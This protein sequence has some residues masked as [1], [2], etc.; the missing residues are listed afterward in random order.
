[1]LIKD[2]ATI[3]SV[4]DFLSKKLEKFQDKQ[5]KDDFEKTKELLRIEKI[6]GEKKMF[7]LKNSNEFDGKSL[8]EYIESENVRLVR[9]REEL[10]DL[11]VKIANL[12]NRDDTEKAMDEVINHYKSGLNS[13]VALRD[14]LTMIKER[15]PWGSN[16]KKIM[17]FVSFVAC[18]LGIGLFVL[19]LTTDLDFGIKMLNKENKSANET[20]NFHSYLSKKENDFNFSSPDS[21]RSACDAYI[22]FY[23]NHTKDSTILDD[24]DY[25]LTGWIAIWH[26][27]QPFVAIMIVFFSINY[28]RGWE[29]V[30]RSFRDIPDLPDFLDHVLCPTPYD[31]LNY[32]LCGVPA[33][34]IL[35]LWYLVL[36][37]GKFVPLPA[38]TNIYR[39]YLDVRCHDA[40]SK[41]DFRTMIVS[42]EG[43][44]RDH[45]ALGQLLKS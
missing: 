44:I 24:E 39:F 1:M 31:K 17:I 12:N 8:L 30:K 36:V 15:Y 2:P 34:L 22:N 14:M 23:D 9:Q 33:L 11:S 21:L 10:I 25:E 41:P 28:S 16:K 43:K 5:N 29:E 27:I 3:S 6:E 7:Y 19:D 32:L 4:L 20:E 35:L 40:R 42:I 18:V 45:E 13:G 38:F 37:L 26:C